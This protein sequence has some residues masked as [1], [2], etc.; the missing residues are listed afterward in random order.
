MANGKQVLSSIASKS[1]CI[2]FSTRELLCQCRP[3][4]EGELVVRPRVVGQRRRAAVRVGPGVV[5]EYSGPAKSH[6]VDDWLTGDGSIHYV[7]AR[8]FRTL[9]NP[10]TL[11]GLATSDST[12][13]SEQT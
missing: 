3:P 10:E 11:F 8:T 1:G 4:E 13:Q 5:V 12:C 9:E 2:Y 6:R 7:N